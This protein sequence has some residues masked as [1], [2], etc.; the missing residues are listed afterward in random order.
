MRDHRIRLGYMRRDEAAEMMLDL[1]SEH[2][3]TDK[4]WI[5]QWMNRRNTYGMCYYGT[6]TLKLSLLF[7]DHNDR[8][9]VLEVCRHEVAHALA[10]SAAKHGPYWQAIAIELGVVNPGP[11]TSGAELPPARYQATCP[12]C[13]KLYSKARPPLPSTNGRYYYCPPCWKSPAFRN[14]PQADRLAVAELKY[15]DSLASSVVSIPRTHERAPVSAAQ[16]APSVV[17]QTTGESAPNAYTAPQLAAAMKV[18]TKK[19]RAWPRRCS[20]GANYQTGPG[21]AYAFSE[22]DVLDVVRAWNATH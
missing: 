1:M 4:G 7:V 12:S 6:K 14:L 18:E 3:L 5:F 11:C 2:R 8:E 10:G 13:A 17:A 19:L 20:L 15:V 21:G 9:K 22:D 16:S